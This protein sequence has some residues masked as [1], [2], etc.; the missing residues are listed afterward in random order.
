VT[1]LVAR[2]AALALLLSSAAAAQAPITPAEILKRVS[3]AV[4][5]EV[6]F[7]E[8]RTTRLLKTPLVS[9]GVL[10]YSPPNR[11]ERETRQPMQEI[12]VIEDLQ[13]TIDRGGSQTVVSLIS[14]SPPATMMRTLRAVLSGQLH[15]LDTLYLASAQGSS[16][17]WTL[18][19]E[20]RSTDTVIRG[21]RLAGSGGTVEEIE[22]L[23]RSGDKTV[24]QL[25]R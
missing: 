8:V 5:P 17:R 1:V 22:V 15:D 2:L 3:A 23:E 18:N 4:S 19:L 10:R 13:V 14:G 16:E 24:T 12:V 6:G 7:R 21:V 11:L 25:S 20:P 9:S